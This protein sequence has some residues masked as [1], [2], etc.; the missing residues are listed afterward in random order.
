MILSKQQNEQHRN[1]DKTVE[2]DNSTGHFLWYSHHHRFAKDL[3]DGGGFLESSKPNTI[4]K[5]SKNIK[6]S[7]KQHQIPNCNCFGSSQGLPEK[8]T[9]YINSSKATTLGLSFLNIYIFIAC[10]N[11]MINPLKI[12]RVAVRKETVKKHTG[13]RY[14]IAKW[15]CTGHILS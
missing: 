7:L 1:E 6:P 14:L 11:D 2:E 3:N 13:K 8:K 15:V 5:L 10:S 9:F 4:P 12:A